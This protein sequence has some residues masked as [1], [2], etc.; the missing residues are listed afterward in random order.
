MTF[1]DCTIQKVLPEHIVLQ[2][3]Q[4]V[5]MTL[6]DTWHSWQDQPFWP[7]HRYRGAEELPTS[8]VTAPI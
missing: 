4:N 2:Y 7:R 3:Q 1:E 8:R 6:Q 5:T